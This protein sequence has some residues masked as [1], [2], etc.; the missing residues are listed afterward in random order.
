VPLAARV[1]FIKQRWTGSMKWGEDDNLGMQRGCGWLTVFSFFMLLWLWIYMVKW[2]LD[3]KDYVT[4]R[5][6]YMSENKTLLFL[7]P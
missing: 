3:L 2:N 4:H 5:P 6:C 7:S 1:L